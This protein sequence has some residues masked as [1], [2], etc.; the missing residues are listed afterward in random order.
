MNRKAKRALKAV[1]CIMD[2]LVNEEDSCS[3]DEWK[4]KDGYSFHADIGCFYKGLVRFK[5]ML[6]RKAKDN[7]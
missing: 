3:S 1:D 2:Y 4:D 6:E 5:K 7:D